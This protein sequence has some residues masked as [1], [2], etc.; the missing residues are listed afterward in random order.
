MIHGCARQNNP[1]CA[2]L[3]STPLRHLVPF[4]LHEHQN[5][6]P[7]RLSLPQAHS[8]NTSFRSQTLSES[9][10]LHSGSPSVKQGNRHQERPPPNS[11]QVTTHGR[12]RVNGASQD[13]R[14]PGPQGHPWKP[15]L[16]QFLQLRLAHSNHGVLHY[17]SCSSFHKAHQAQPKSYRGTPT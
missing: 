8:F 9:N 14:I 15:T 7:C 2:C 5:F 10:V 16:P 4:L 6:W 17:G 13:P 3:S 12:S 1:Q 11:N